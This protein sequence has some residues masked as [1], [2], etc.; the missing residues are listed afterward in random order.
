MQGEADLGVRAQPLHCHALFFHMARSRLSRGEQP[1][2]SVPKEW[3]HAI[4]LLQ[5]FAN[6]AR[7]RNNLGQV[8]EVTFSPG[9]FGSLS[10]RR[11][12]NPGRGLPLNIVL[13][14]ADQCTDSSAARKQQS[15]Q[16]GMQG[17]ARVRRKAIEKPA[18]VS[19]GNASNA[20]RF[21]NH[22]V[23]ESQ[24]RAGRRQNT[25]LVQLTGVLRD[26]VSVDPT[27]SPDGVVRRFYAVVVARW[28]P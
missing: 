15:H 23:H 25:R 4:D 19:P 3:T 9:H 8:N 24:R 7:N 11:D 6:G 20:L 27:E 5:D 18:Q 2:V 14:A 22:V 26:P 10:M 13:T 16:K 28:G 12:Y 1:G 21:W 17:I